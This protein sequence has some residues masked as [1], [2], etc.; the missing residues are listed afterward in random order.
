VAVGVEQKLGAGPPALRLDPLEIRP[1]RHVKARKCVT[2]PVRRESS[3]RSKRFRDSR[4]EDSLAKVVGVEETSGFVGEDQ[5]V[6]AEEVGAAA[7]Q[8]LA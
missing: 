2:K 1:P 6:W 5:G 4:S 7:C 8:L 3:P